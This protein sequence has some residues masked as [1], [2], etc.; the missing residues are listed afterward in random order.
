MAA[1]HTD[2]YQTLE[3]YFGRLDDAPVSRVGICA[4]EE[5]KQWYETVLMHAY[6][7]YQAAKYHYGNLT[8]FLEE[9]SRQDTPVEL[10]KEL[11]ARNVT[12]RS[13]R[14]IDVD[15]YA[16]ELSAFLAAL[17]SALDFTATA[18]YRHFKGLH[19]D[20]ISHLLHLEESGKTGPILDQVR[21]HHKW[22]IKLRSYRDQVVHR[23]VLTLQSYYEFHT[24][25][26]KSSAARCPVVVPECLDVNVLDTRRSR[27]QDDVPLG[28]ESCEMKMWEQHEDGTKKLISYSKEYSPA[29]GYLSI[30]EFMRGHLAA[31][32]D[33]FLDIISV[34]DTLDFKTIVEVDKG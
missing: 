32:S 25:G 24:I 11:A 20:G 7:K 21:H 34:L 3:A 28:I 29:P 18:C 14:S 19:G 13:K 9:D 10:P 33:F 5:S 1:H 15:R 8:K 6:R 27:M 4:S 26:G 16:H 31:F 17:K 30:D 2:I 12:M 22:L 23:K